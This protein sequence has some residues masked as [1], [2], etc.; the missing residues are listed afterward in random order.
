MSKEIRPYATRLRS[1]RSR[2]GLSQVQLALAGGLSKATQV[3]YEGD[4]HVP[5]LEY[6]DR[7]ATAGADKIYLCTGIPE[8]EFVAQR[9]DWGLHNDIVL[10]I[11]EWAEDHDVR[12]PQ[13]KL[14]D[15]IHLLYDEFVRTG[16]VEPEV[17]ARALR[18]VA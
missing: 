12:V 1:E 4:T 11:H 16:T 9:F 5:D 17:L 2:L 13:G 14:T 15:L 10:A 6:L 8:A 18:L 3:A 7:I